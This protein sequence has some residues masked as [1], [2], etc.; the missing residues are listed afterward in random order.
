MLA[1]AVCSVLII[2][3][4][5]ALGLAIPTAVMVGTGRGAKRGILIRDIDALQRAET[6]DTAVLDKTGTITRGRPV[7]AEVMP[8]DGAS[9]DVVLS[10]AAAAEM[11]SEHPVAKA[12]V[13][14]A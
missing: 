12:I 7:V 13:A 11:F 14:H 5:C 2:A 10:H 1:K 4:P 3:C 6:I 9:S 8:L